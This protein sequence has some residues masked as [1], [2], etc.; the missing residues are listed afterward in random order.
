MSKIK[1]CSSDN[2]NS[3]KKKNSK[4][5]YI[6]RQTTKVHIPYMNEKIFLKISQIF[7]KC[8]FSS[9]PKVDINLSPIVK[10]GKDPLNKCD[11]TNVA[12]K[13]T[14]KNC[15]TTYI[16]ETKRSLKTRINEHKNKK[17]TESVICQH[18][19]DYNHEFNCEETTILDQESNY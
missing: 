16:G 11:Q 12:Y 7:Q 8:N 17:S 13:F 15:P 10:L 9:I 1:Y 14:C 4:P 19:M 3:N 5:T 18:Q 6:Y 2:N